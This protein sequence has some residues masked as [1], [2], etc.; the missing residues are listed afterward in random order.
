MKKLIVSGYLYVRKSKI[1]NAGRGVF[2][3]RAIRKGGLIE[4]CP[5]IELSEA[6][7][8][9]INESFLVTYLFYF[10]K[11]KER[12]ALALGFG[13]IYNHS[14]K[15]NAKF[16]ILPSENLVEFTALTDI[17]KDDEITFNYTGPGIN[18]PPLWFEV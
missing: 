3:G 8:S 13:S 11:N 17:K 10:G 2:A 14:Y 16:K 18:F 4:R 1:K 6:D 7:N 9:G 12:S 5:L 15:P